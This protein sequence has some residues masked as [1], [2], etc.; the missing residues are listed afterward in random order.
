MGLRLNFTIYKPKHH[1]ADFI[2]AI[3]CAKTCDTNHSDVVRCLNGDGCMGVLF[4]L[5]KSLRIGNQALPTG[6]LVQ[7]VS[8][9]THTISIPAGSTV[10]GIRFQPGF[11]VSILDTKPCHPKVISSDSDIGQVL[12]PIFQQLS[13]AKGSWTLIALIYR[14]ICQHLG[15]P[16]PLPHSLKHAIDVLQSTAHEQ[17]HTTVFN[18]RQ[19]ERQ[20]KTWLGITP[21]HF[22]RIMRVRHTLDALKQH[23]EAPLAAIAQQLGYSDQ[24]HMTRELKHIAN[25][26]PNKYRHILNSQG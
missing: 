8:I 26:T 18:Q 23:N 7:P 19:I 5:N 12:L 25:V 11:G 16:Q 22:H 21:K 1:I 13:H 20:F 3:W 9:Q 24:A 4:N 14:W 2:Q 15:Q 10:V 17:Q 6:V